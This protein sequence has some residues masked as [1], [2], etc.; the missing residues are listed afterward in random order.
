MDE[1]T[2]WLVNEGDVTEVEWGTPMPKLD[3]FG[4]D[5]VIVEAV[6]QAGA[7]AI[8]DKI[9]HRCDEHRLIADEIFAAWEGPTVDWL[10][11]HLAGAVEIEDGQETVTCVR[12]GA[13]RTDGPSIN[14]LTNER[15]AG[16]SAVI[17]KPG[18][19]GSW[20]LED[21]PSQIGGTLWHL[22]AAGAQ[23]YLV[24]GEVNGRGSDGEVTLANVKLLSRLSYSKALGGFVEI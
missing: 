14:H 4:I 1:T 24:T 10:Q 8:A 2:I 16:V 17:A 6:D 3:A 22:V 21:G 13:P 15:E 9:D 18:Q 5:W 19:D 11:W 12:F 7:L 20:L 23:P